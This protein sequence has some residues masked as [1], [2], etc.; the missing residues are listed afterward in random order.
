MVPSGF[1]TGVTSTDS[2]EIGASAAAKIFWTEAAISGPIPSPGMS[3]TVLGSLRTDRLYLPLARRMLPTCLLTGSWRKVSVTEI[4][5]STFCVCNDLRYQL[6]SSWWI[7]STKAR[8]SSNTTDW[9]LF[10]PHKL[11]KTTLETGASSQQQ[12]T[13][14]TVKIGAIPVVMLSIVDMK[15]INKGIRL[16][17]FR[18]VKNTRIETDAAT[19]E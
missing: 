13:P 11:C 19:Q 18:V 16:T 9:S 14:S 7:K 6:S 2:Q 17:T 5:F 3:V 12:A 1:L 4:T 8:L 10:Y 15:E